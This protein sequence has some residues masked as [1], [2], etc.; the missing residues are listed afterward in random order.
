MS[1]ENCYGGAVRAVNAV[2]GLPNRVPTPI[3]PL[4]GGFLFRSP[5]R[6]AQMMVKLPLIGEASYSGRGLF[7]GG[8][9]RQ[10]LP[11]SCDSLVMVTGSQLL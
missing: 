8:G 10:A 6:R 4:A 2:R 1:R 9:R 11:R 3:M 7:G 5:A